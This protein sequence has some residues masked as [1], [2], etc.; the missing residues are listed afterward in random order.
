MKKGHYLRIPFAIAISCAL[1]S[2]SSPSISQEEW[3]EIGASVASSMKFDIAVEKTEAQ[4]RERYSNRHTCDYHEWDTEECIHEVRLATLKHIVSRYY[5][6]SDWDAIPTMRDD[7]KASEVWT[8]IQDAIPSASK[9]L[10]NVAAV[11]QVKWTIDNV[12]KEHDRLNRVEFKL[13]EF[14]SKSKDREVFK[15]YCTYNDTYYKIVRTSDGGY[16]WDFSI[17]FIE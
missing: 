12:A 9:K 7:F 11:E 6:T 14:V 17:P 2:C 3:N 5:E 15:S 13:P 16:L 8:E 1:A 4:A 10:R